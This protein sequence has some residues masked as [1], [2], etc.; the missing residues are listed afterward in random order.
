[1]NKKTKE[2]IICICIAIGY[3]MLFRLSGLLVPH[4]G[5][6]PDKNSNIYL[7]QL[8]GEVIGVV[9][10]VIATFIFKKTHIFRER[11]KGIPAA[12][13]AGGYLM[14]VALVTFIL[15]LV[16]DFDASKIRPVSHIIT[17]VICMILVG[18]SEEIIFR[19]IIQNRLMD[20]FGRD[21]HNGMVKAVITSGLIFA[22]IHITNVFTGVTL[23]GAVLQ[24]LA[25][26]GTGCL[27]GAIYARC[28][29][30]W[31]MML[32][33]GI[34]DFCALAATGLQF[35]SGDLTSK[36]SD[37]NPASLIGSA[38]NVAIALFLL[39]REK[40]DYSGDK[41][42]ETANASADK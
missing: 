38:I 8:A 26:I 30:I 4:N 5:E 20:A 40:M 31:A 11:G 39:R 22:L 34:I 18:A 13:I 37:T 1:M 16:Q 23:R 9:I 3:I 21:T 24:A 14:F 29:N 7:I 41:L 32:L 35:D 15:Y 12:F 33:H 19:G 42:P 28:N 27:F 2:I 10:G 6:E 25:V 36:L 17:F